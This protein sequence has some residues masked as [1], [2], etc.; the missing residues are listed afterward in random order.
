MSKKLATTAALI[1]AGT[2]AHAQDAF[3]TQLGSNGQAINYS[4]YTQGP[5]TSDNLQVIAQ[6]GDN[7]TAGNFTRGSN[8]T[9][10]AYQLNSGNA[11][12][13][14]MGSLI[15]QNGGANTAIAVQDNS[16]TFGNNNRTY[17]SQI[18]QEGITNTAINWNQTA[19]GAMAGLSIGT[20]AAPSI[21]IAPGANPLPVPTV[22]TTNA[23]LP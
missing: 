13:S 18:I 10:M 9:A 15:F 23:T 11:P 8:S 22:T 4:E 14:T 21:T 16:P 3:I 7:L 19:G 5:S 20:I 17:V 12:G 1:I 2:A 6:E